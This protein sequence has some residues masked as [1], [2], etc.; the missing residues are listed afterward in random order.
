MIKQ[1][2]LQQLCDG[3][4]HSGQAL[5]DD[6]Q[7]SRS[8]V[9]KAI[10][11]LQQ[12]FS[13]HVHAV[14][15]RGYCLS[16][17]VELLDAEKIT[18]LLSSDTNAIINN[19]Y[20]FLSIQSTNEFLMSK[21]RSE[22]ITQCEICFAETQLAGRGRRGKNWVSPFGGNLY[23]S[24]SWNFTQGTAA[25]TGLSIAFAVGIVKYLQ[26]LGVN[27]LQLKWPNDILWKHKKLC[28]ILLEVSGEASGSCAVIIGVGLNISMTSDNETSIDQ[29]WIDL[30]SILHQLPTRNVLAADLITVLVKTIL[31]FEKNGLSFFQHHWSEY[32]YT[33]NNHITIKQP[34]RTNTGIARGIDRTGALIVEQN[35]ILNTFHSG[36]V[37]IRLKK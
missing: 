18:K 27:G 31:E 14:R 19:I 29:P 15:G 28:G 32:D 34:N 33:K 11:A 30:V 9:W 16:N 22:K 5:A 36:D 6:L 26:D 3:N 37:S 17:K 25:T 35:G 7:C 1:Q 12:E 8:A 4:F 20:T 13:I 24:F 23:C 21:S 10:K 2:I